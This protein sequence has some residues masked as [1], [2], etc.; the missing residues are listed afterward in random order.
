MFNSTIFHIIIGYDNLIIKKKGEQSQHLVEFT[1]FIPNVPFYYHF[2]DQD[3][4]YTKDMKSLIKKLKIRNAIVIVPD[5][6]IDIEVDRKIFTDFF[7]QCGVKKV[8]LKSQ[9][10][11]LSSD[12]KKYISIS[13]N[14][15]N[16]VLQYIVNDKYIVKKYYDRNYADV[17]Q[18]ALDTK[19]LHADCE[20]DSIPI[21]I[22]NINNDMDE[23]MSIGILVNL[24]NYIAN[25]E[26]Y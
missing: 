4:T 5:D 20:Y 1:S 6:A 10:F 18:I 23:F 16:I 26:N 17:K 14:T 12:N 2:F 11:F 15:R 25:I 21:Y 24:D 3:K 13:R 9:C 19:R 7:M 8:Q 22:N